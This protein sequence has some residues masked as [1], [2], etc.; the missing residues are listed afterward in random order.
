MNVHQRA[1]HE[2]NKQYWNASLLVITISISAV[3]R[4]DC[5][6]VLQVPW[7]VVL[8]LGGTVAV[9]YRSLAKVA[10]NDYSNY[11]R[12]LVNTMTWTLMIL[13]HQY[14]VHGRQSDHTFHLQT[15]TCAYFVRNVQTRDVSTKSCLSRQLMRYTVLAASNEELK[16]RIGFE[17]LIAI[18]ACYHAECRR[19]EQRKQQRS[20]QSDLS[21]AYPDVTVDD[22]MAAAW[23]QL[24]D[25]LDASF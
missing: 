2:L 9:T 15:T 3:F 19:D 25:E 8:L 6:V 10:F 17:D 12:Q 14:N 16:Y 22:P 5:L 18:E 21:T 7:K 4:V 1:C 23:Q 24:L 13:L 20:I 11:S